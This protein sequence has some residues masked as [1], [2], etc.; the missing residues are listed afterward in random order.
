MGVRDRQPPP[1]GSPSTKY[2]ELAGNRELID[3]MRIRHLDVLRKVYEVHDGM[4]PIDLMLTTAMS[5]SY[6]LVEG[7]IAAFDSWNFFAAAPLLR[8]QI[9]TLV[10]LSYM[11]RAE[12]S[13][14]IA[15]QFITGV[16]FRNMKDPEG[17]KLV[18]RHL[19]ELASEFHP[20]IKSIYAAT[21]GWVHFSPEH[22]H[23]TWKLD[24]RTK[25]PDTIGTIQSRI[26]MGPDAVPAEMVAD[27]LETMIEVTKVVFAYAEAW[28]SR[29][30][31]PPGE[32]REI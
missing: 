26:P 7:F 14:E 6:S 13:E 22:F 24:E 4:F 18:D 30:G 11:S 9:D 25:E 28:T 23:A 27:I 19:N 15:R 2:P 29:K 32:M 31:M 16:E 8:M 21:S 3:S 12:D 5:R 17:N 20:W 1:D 10:R